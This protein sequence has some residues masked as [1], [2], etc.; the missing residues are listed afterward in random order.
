M[1]KLTAIVGT[2][3]VAVA[4]TAFVA[5]QDATAPRETDRGALAPPTAGGSGAVLDSDLESTLLTASDDDTLVVVVRY[6]ASATSGEELA[7]Q[8]MDLGAGARALQELPFVGAYATPDQVRS[9]ATFSG[10]IR[11][12]PNWELRWLGSPTAAAHVAAMLDQSASTINAE[13]ARD[14]YGVTGSG[15]GVA[16]LDTG[17]DGL[18]DDVQFPSRTVQ[19]VKFLLDPED[20]FCFSNEPCPSTVYVENLE[21]TDS[22]G[23]GTHVGGIAGG[24][25]VKS[26]GR[27]TGVAPKADLVGLSTGDAGFLF[28]VLA[29]FDY[30][31]AH[32]DAYNIQV[33]NNS[34]GPIDPEEFDPENPVNVATKI[35]HDAGI[36]VVFAGGNDGPEQGTMNQ[37]ALAPWTIGVAAACSDG[38]DF[39]QEAHC[40][41]GRL[42]DFSSRG[43]PGDDFNRPDITAPGVHVVSA[44]AAG[45]AGNPFHDFELTSECG[46]T[47]EEA[48]NYACLSGTSMAAPHVAGVVALMQERAD[49]KLSPDKVKDIL[50]KSAADMEGF[51]PYQVGAGMTDAL[52]AVARSNR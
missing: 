48:L 39:A 45:T 18:H 3:A 8:I 9:I 42:A 16:I 34:W 26:D 40:S 44:R 37:Y 1:R 14:K 36:T 27:F 10:V 23:H 15:V 20:G 35:V 5:C 13:A 38:D 12:S 30:I 28:W 31:L 49:G 47:E 29:G 46:M 51:E 19:N 7:G 32:Q 6:D 17:V 33:V 2:T 24:N 11:I 43:V 4:A 22:H 50:V 21:D 52:A 41:G 25:G